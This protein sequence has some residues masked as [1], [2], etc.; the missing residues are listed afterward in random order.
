MRFA[1]ILCCTKAAILGIP[2]IPAPSLNDF[3]PHR[4][5]RYL[6]CNQNLEEP[7]NDRFGSLFAFQNVE[8]C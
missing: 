2:C 5:E 6:G 1:G 3:G 8:V 7:V 4:T